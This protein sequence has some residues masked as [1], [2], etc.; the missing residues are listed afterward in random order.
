VRDGIDGTALDHEQI[1]EGAEVLHF[2]GPIPR[3]HTEALREAAEC[4]CAAAAGTGRSD[5]SGLT[6]RC[7]TPVMSSAA[8]RGRIR[9]LRV[10]IAAGQRGVLR[11]ARQ[12]VRGRAEGR[13]R[14]GHRVHEADGPSVPL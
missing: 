4:G 12:I 2:R 8:I 5:D 9:R 7:L 11:R 1:L 10:A 6:P 13:S 14:G 3:A